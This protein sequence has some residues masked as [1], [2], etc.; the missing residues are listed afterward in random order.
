M[1]FMGG[2]DASCST[3][4]N[5]LN[6]FSK[7]VQDD[8]SLQRDRL[9]G[10]G[11]GGGMQEGFRSAREAPGQGNELAQMM[12]AF[13]SQQ[14]NTMP[15]PPA[16]A[17]AS[18]LAM[19]QMRREFESLQTRGPPPQ[20][21]NASPANWA[22]EFDPGMQQQ[23]GGT[24]QHME[25][26][27]QN[28]QKNG[29]F[30]ISEFHRYVQMRTA[31]TNGQQ[32][33]TPIANGG[34]GVNGFQRPMGYGG[35]GYGGMGTMNG[36]MGMNMMQ[37][38]PMAGV[39]GFQQQQNNT[40]AHSKGNERVMELDEKDW[41]AQ[42]A[43]IESGAG[44]EASQA[45]GKLDQEASRAAEA[46][47]DQLDRSV[48]SQ[49]SVPFS[50]QQKPIVDRLD[51]FESIWQQ[52]NAEK[53][54]FRDFAADKLPD[55]REHMGELSDW[56]NFDSTS[57]DL[58]THL[59][60]DPAMGNY[61]FE[62]DNIFGDTTD[63]FGEGVHIM[64]TGG[65]L[66]LA[67]LAFESAVQRDPKHVQAWTRLGA[68]QAQNEKETPAIRALEQ[69]LRIDP[70]CLDAMMGLAV[71]YTNEGYEATSYR[72]LLRWL[73][74]KYPQFADDFTRTETSAW[75]PQPKD[76]TSISNFN[77]DIGFTDRAALHER[78]TALFIKAAQLSPD[79]STMDPDVQVGLG[80]LFYA[81]DSFDR[82]VDCFNA[83]LSSSESGMSNS[84]PANQLP[85]LWN[86]LGATLANSG[87]SEEA[88]GAYEEALRLNSNFVR[89]RYN[90]GVSCINMQCYEAAAQHLLG[91]LNDHKM[92]EREGRQKA[93]EMM[94]MGSEGQE[95]SKM[96][97]DEFDRMARFSHN[98]STNL[99]ETLRRVFRAMD[100]RDL[101]D[102]VGPGMELEGFRGEFEF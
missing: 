71:S 37:Q 69:A 46:E 59:G 48:P 7:H 52:I 86:R 13:M 43:Q 58:T 97:D 36:G 56:E 9:V 79:P 80:V 102:R 30:D 62:E 28:M 67:A 76:P 61:M 44:Q 22:A 84:R 93:R 82:A 49:S 53:N 18:P 27:F 25:G 101:L 31:E 78:V 6:Q 95:G 5:P 4:S 14:P 83:A 42:F 81:T 54:S 94:D 3:G 10:R 35:M 75:D 39:N 23:R 64:D 89:A 1:S 34:N 33:D 16:A 87:R 73:T 20:H 77:P 91:A 19:E 63:P 68:A 66:S 45:D 11:P 65:N 60:R 70:S 47:L 38:R 74:T 41:E 88:I 26:G 100:R 99:Y 50:E 12:D 17:P 96:G 29:D 2:G 90:L 92:V 15:Q 24:P 40:A 55:W 51:D 85:L 21:R 8:N 32:S 98:Q 72:I 57:A